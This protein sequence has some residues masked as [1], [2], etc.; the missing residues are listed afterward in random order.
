MK[1][2][3]GNL[4]KVALCLLL[5]SGFIV[6]P[7]VMAESGASAP[8]QVKDFKQDAVDK[9]KQAA[10]DKNAKYSAEAVAA[11]K[12]VEQAIT[13]LDEGKH[14][15]AVKKLQEADGKLEIAM[16]AD[17]DLKLIPV[18]ASVMSYDLITTPKAVT[19]EL[20][21]VNKLLQA[22]DVQ[23][24]RLRLARLRSEIVAN[25]VYL[26]AETYPDAIKRAVEQITTKQA[27]MARDTLADAMGSLAE[28]T[29]V[30]PLP[31][32]LA[33]GAILEAEQIRETDKDEAL[34][35][36]AYASDQIETAERL[37]YFYGN[38]D[39]YKAVTK[40]IETLQNAIAGKNKIEEL[41]DNAKNSMKSL[42][43]KA[44]GKKIES[45]Q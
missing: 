25:Y 31:V 32:V 19:A 41:F 7:P 35:D 1:I 5:S 44:R 23:D 42:L 39:D 40:H 29:E 10:K 9:A 27:G 6:V 20:A 18:A 34:Q 33:Q 38:K 22:G 4:H 21:E 13:L 28:E 17:P 15:E 45:K 24:A 12:A 36:L 2:A 8:A 26:P 14:D 30:T 37:G 43:N 11:I 16:A 3:T